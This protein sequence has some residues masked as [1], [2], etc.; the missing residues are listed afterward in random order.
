MLFESHIPIPG[1]VPVPIKVRDILS[2]DCNISPS[3]NYLKLSRILFLTYISHS[4]H[5]LP[6]I[7]YISIALPKSA[8]QAIDIILWVIMIDI[9]FTAISLDLAQRDTSIL[10]WRHNFIPLHNVESLIFIIKS[11]HRLTSCICFKYKH[12][13]VIMVDF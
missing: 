1:T 5:F 11:S 7:Q 13:K 10:H 3:E 4:Q 9:I 2:S 6:K 8:V 12:K